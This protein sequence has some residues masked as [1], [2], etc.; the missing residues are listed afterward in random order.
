MASEGG[1]EGLHA[2]ISVWEKYGFPGGIIIGALA[3]AISIKRGWL[4]IGDRTKLAVAL[5]VSEK[6]IEYLQSEIASLKAQLEEAQK[7]IAT[8]STEGGL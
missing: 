2:L 8:N 1:P 6:E 5:A 3:V 4:F 7:I